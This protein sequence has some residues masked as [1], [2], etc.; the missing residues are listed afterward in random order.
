[1]RAELVDLGDQT[2]TLLTSSSAICS[3]KALLII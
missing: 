2:E 3:M 1:M